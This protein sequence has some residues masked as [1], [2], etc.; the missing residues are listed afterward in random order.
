MKV[1]RWILAIALTLGLSVI[2]RANDYNDD[3]V[4]LALRDSMS[5]AF[6]TGDSAHFFTAVT[7]LEDYLLSKDDLHNYYTQRCNEIIFMMNHQK[8]FE[9]YKA[10]QQLSKELREKGLDKEMY[11]A[12]NMMGHINRYCGNY[13][14]AKKSFPRSHRPD[15]EIWLLRK[16]AT[17]LY[18][19]CQHR[20]GRRCQRSP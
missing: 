11:M 20:D 15:G 17:H 9:A 3:E 1:K 19:Y 4:Y 14:A 12:I 6:N 5:Y 10:A 8:I 13:D 7:K 18:E 2:A 16:H